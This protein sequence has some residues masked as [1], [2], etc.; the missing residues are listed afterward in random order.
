MRETCRKFGI[1]GYLTPLIL[2]ARKIPTEKTTMARK[3]K[4]SWLL[5]AFSG[6][7]GAI[8]AT[9]IF[10][11]VFSG[12]SLF[13]KVV[14]DPIPGSVKNIHA[15]RQRGWSR[16]WRMRRYVLR[17]GISREDLRKITASGPFIKLDYA[18]YGEGEIAYGMT[19]R[20]EYRLALYKSSR[21]EPGWFDLGK[22]SG[23]EAYIKEREQPE[24][25]YWTK[26]LLYST[27]LSEAYFIDH[28]EEGTLAG[29]CSVTNPPP[30]EMPQWMKRKMEEARRKW[31]DRQ[32]K[33]G[34][35]PN[36]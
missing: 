5:L 6:G 1:P 14:I 23:Y 26:I 11:T 8:L 21:H 15:D 32:P 7:G 28:F 22:W 9:L 34:A 20:P 10:L 3:V 24:G 16:D 12:P 18:E 30:E 13:R 31:P 17:F 4:N 35:D 2:S 27:Q 36:A 19:G 29:A 33:S 25:W